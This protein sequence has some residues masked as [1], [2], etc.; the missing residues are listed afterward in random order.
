MLFVFSQ[1][2]IANVLLVII[3][4]QK[5]KTIFLLRLALTLALHG[6]AATA[7]FTIA[8]VCSTWSAVNLA[9]SKRDILTPYGD[10]SLAGVRSANRMVARRGPML[11]AIFP[12]SH[13][14]FMLIFRLLL[15]GYDIPFF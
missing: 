10:V 11:T 6:L 5:F 15:T 2:E 3:P 1:S 12:L 9:T 8:V 4:N 7:L 14:L 13:F